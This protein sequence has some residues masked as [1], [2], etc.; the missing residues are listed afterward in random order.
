[1][2]DRLAYSIA[3]AAQLLG[4]SQSTVRRE[5]KAGRLEVA[6]VGRRVLVKAESI[7]TRLF[8]DNPF[9]GLRP[10]LEHAVEVFLAPLSGRIQ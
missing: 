2:T 1:M 10:E 4:V 7:Q 6:R 5:I 8:I 3:E 9:E